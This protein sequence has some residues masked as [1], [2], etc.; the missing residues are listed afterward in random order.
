L[1]HVG[2]R[3]CGPQRRRGGLPSG[4]GF[5]VLARELLGHLELPSLLSRSESFA[6]S[7]ACFGSGNE[8]LYGLIPNFVDGGALE[9][10]QVRD[11]AA[12]NNVIPLIGLCELGDVLRYPELEGGVLIIIQQLHEPST[13]FVV[14]KES[15][16][17][18][19]SFVLLRKLQ[20]GLAVVSQEVVF[21]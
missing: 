12:F 1:I 20:R 17:I 19:W 2:A 6:V 14:G 18:G 8:G 7:S 11:G 16:D 4:D 3:R 21:P 13:C 5:S 10:Y 15:N 9:P